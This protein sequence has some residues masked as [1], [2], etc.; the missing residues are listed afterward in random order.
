MR[1]MAKWIGI[2]EHLVF[3]SIKKPEDNHHLAE[4]ITEKFGPV[5]VQTIV[6][7]MNEEVPD[8][9]NATLI[10]D[11][12]VCEIRRPKL[13]FVQAKVYFCGKPNI[14]ALKKEVRVN[15]RSGTA[16]IIS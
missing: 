6:R 14:Y 1:Y 12:T 13:P 2:L 9:Q 5:S 11:C 8:T 7:F 4:V 10:V 3:P 16:A 15:I